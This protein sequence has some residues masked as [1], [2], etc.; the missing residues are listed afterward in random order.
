MKRKN[1]KTATPT[2]S[3]VFGSREPQTIDFDPTEKQAFIFRN[4]GNHMLVVAWDLDASGYGVYRLKV[5][6]EK[7][8]RVVY[9]ALEPGNNSA[10]FFGEAAVVGASK[11]DLFTSFGYEDDDIRDADGHVV[12]KIKEIVI[13]PKQE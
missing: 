6:G 13:R 4:G 8:G 9:K 5:I 3:F 2:A 10:A 1:N 11:T 7:N 12:N